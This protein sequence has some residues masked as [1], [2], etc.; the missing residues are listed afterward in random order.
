MYP[1]QQPAAPTIIE[2][3]LTM[4]RF[5]DHGVG[6]I[7]IEVT[8]SYDPADPFAVTVVLH[9]EGGPVRWLFA[10]DLL[11]DGMFAP[12]GEEAGDVYAWP[13][14]DNAG[15]AVVIVELRSPSGQLIGQ[16][17]ARDLAR[18]VRDMLGAVPLGSE[19]DHADMDAV[20]ER[21]LQPL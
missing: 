21:L 14:L 11:V 1:S 4:E 7:P 2:S 16:I 10:R 9:A 18:F 15:V 8:L 20:V 17:A 13:C 12:A 3:H 5:V 6:T 19:G